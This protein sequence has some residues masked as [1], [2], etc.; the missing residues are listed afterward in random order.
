MFYIKR[1][2]KF[3]GLRDKAALVVSRGIESE[4]IKQLFKQISGSKIKKS[5]IYYNLDNVLYRVD[6]IT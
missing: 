5:N 6:V 3:P 1:K 4:K 2:K